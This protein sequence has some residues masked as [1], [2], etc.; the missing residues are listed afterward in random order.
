MKTLKFCL[1]V[2]VLS[3]CGQ[4]YGQNINTN[5]KQELTTALEEFLKCKQSSR[6]DCNQFTGESLNKI[7]KVNDFYSQKLGRYMAN[8]EIPGFVRNSDQWTLLGHSYEQHVLTAAQEYANS[9]KAVIAV[10]TNPEGAGHVVI[11]TPG[12]LHPSGSWSMKVPSAVSFFPTEPAKSFVDKGLSYAFAK[13][14][15]KDVLIY[16]RKY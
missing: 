13:N 4:S 1:L 9:K 14:M 15:L 6:T 3:W 7:Y 12:E 10:Y 5:W 2:M 11:I 16:G 8:N